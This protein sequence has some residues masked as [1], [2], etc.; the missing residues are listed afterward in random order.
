MT[1]GEKCNQCKWKEIDR[2]EHEGWTQI[3]WRDILFKCEK[4]G[5]LL[6]IKI[7]ERQ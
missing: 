5:K 2:L 7:G 1:K 4:C 6:K 3:V